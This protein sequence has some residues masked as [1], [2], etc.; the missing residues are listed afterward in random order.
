MDQATQPGAEAQDLHNTNGHFEVTS[1]YQVDPQ[2]IKSAVEAVISQDLAI[3]Q[4]AQRS[5][6]CF[7]ALL[8]AVLEKVP[9]AHP[10][11]VATQLV[12]RL[13]AGAYNVPAI[14]EAFQLGVVIANNLRSTSREHVAKKPST[15]MPDQS[16]GR[17]QEIQG[18]APVASSCYSPAKPI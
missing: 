2:V 9:D 11:S 16:F 5:Y 1:P 10:M 3:S 15:D 4:A 8:D 7:A 17:V 14:L 13:S 18:L 12:E 6:H